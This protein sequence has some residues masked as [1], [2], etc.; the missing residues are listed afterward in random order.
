MARNAG[1]HELPE[2]IKKAMEIT[3]KIMTKT[4]YHV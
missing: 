1:A 2:A 3:S 4:A